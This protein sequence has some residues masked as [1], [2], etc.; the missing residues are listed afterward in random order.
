[1][2]SSSKASTHS[3]SAILVAGD[4]FPGSR[5][6]DER[7]NTRIGTRHLRRSRK[8]RMQTEVDFFRFFVLQNQSV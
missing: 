5:A 7:V 8:R 2:V 6:M 3:E 1:M 4:P